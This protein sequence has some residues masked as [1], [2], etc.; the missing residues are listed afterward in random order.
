MKRIAGFTLVE[1]LVAV[2]ILAVVAALA[3]GG[4]AAI[5]RSRDQIAS[6]QARLG[7]LSRAL[8]RFESDLRAVVDRP[9]REAAGASVPALRGEPNR[10]ELTRGLPP[11]LIENSE[12]DLR[13]VAW[14]LGA[15]GLE[16]T[17]WPVLDRP[18]SVALS[19]E[20]LLPGVER[21]ELRY[22][23]R[24]GRW[25]DRWQQTDGLPRGVELRLQVEALGELRRVVE[26]PSDEVP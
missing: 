1:V 19:V 21:V 16:R 11:S 9:V 7:D 13:R 17:V 23:D 18:A 26:L 5:A 10:L 3:W 22:L 24:Q 8:G 2:A 15:D 4:L 25:V 14:G 6:E 20:T 12:P